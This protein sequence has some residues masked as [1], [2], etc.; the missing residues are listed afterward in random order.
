MRSRKSKTEE[1]VDHH[2]WVI[3]YAD[4]ITLLFAFFVVMYAISSVNTAK[5]KS[6]SEGMKTAFSK[7]DQPHEQQSK[8]DQK[9]G[10]YT[11]K[12]YGQ[13]QDGLDEI[14]Q[15][16]SQLEDKNYKINR[17]KG[18]IELD[19]KSGALFGSGDVDLKADALVKLMQLAEKLKKSHAI[20]S[21]EGYTD[22]MPIETPQYP[23]NWELS[24]ARAAAV[25]RI[26]NSYG[27]DTSR[28]MV[29]GYGEQYPM[30]DNASEVGRALNRRVSIIIAVDRNNKRL[31]NPALNK[32]VHRVV[33]GK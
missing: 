1:H 21:I 31:L 19:I 24:A 30:S 5:Y 28:L 27:I 8:E 11:K 7:M 10:P 17:Q 13:Y 32:Q 3:S 2:R 4:F 25:G 9:K 14:N 18:W 26:L 20:V 6:L 15:S 33:V 29:T 22:N 16:L 23:S 12:V